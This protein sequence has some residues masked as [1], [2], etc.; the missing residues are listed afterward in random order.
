M[1]F[2][3]EFLDFYLYAVSGKKSL[4]FRIINKLT[5]GSYMRKRNHKVYETQDKVRITNYID[6]EAHRE[7]LLQAL[8]NMKL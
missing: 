3:D 7:L 1:K 6:C 4:L 2:A 5:K 8:A